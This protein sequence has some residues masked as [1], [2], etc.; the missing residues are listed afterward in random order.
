[1]SENANYL[2]QNFNIFICQYVASQPTVF[3]ACTLKIYHNKT[4]WLNFLIIYS[5]IQ[6][7]SLTHVLHYTFVNKI[8]RD[9]TVL[10][11]VTVT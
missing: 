4:T 2:S 5:K 8:T 1:M 9:S 3:L 6:F 7:S 10:H 11:H